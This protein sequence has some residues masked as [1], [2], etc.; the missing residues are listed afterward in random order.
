MRAICF[1]TFSMMKFIEI[2]E[3]RA[4]TRIM[5]YK[6][7]F[8]RITCRFYLKKIIFNFYN[9]PIVNKFLCLSNCIRTQL[10]SP[11]HVTAFEIYYRKS[12]L[13]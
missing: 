10:L 4:F 8:R 2:F 1:Q 11:C 7:R 5:S 9:P 13:Y 3:A 6:I 12:S